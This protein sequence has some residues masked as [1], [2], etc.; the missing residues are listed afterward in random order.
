MVN[1]LLDTMV[2]SELRKDPP[3]PSVIQFLED[4]VFA[5][6]FLGVITIGEIADGIG[7]MPAGARRVAY[8][9]WLHDIREL[10][11]DRVLPV[12][13]DVAELWGQLSATVHRSGRKLD[14]ADG[15]IAATALAHGL[16]VVTR[17]VKDFRE[18]GV[19]ITDPWQGSDEE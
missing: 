19:R 2:I 1:Y 6:A 16:T 8:A 3:Q 11:V 9:T 13:E 17:N 14:V 12:S 15:L 4:V 5:E 10:F 7:R 18:T